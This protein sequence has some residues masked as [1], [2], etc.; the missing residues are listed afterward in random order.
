MF[1]LIK[2][3]SCS[4]SD[5]D[6]KINAVHLRPQERQVKFNSALQELYSVFS[7]W[8]A[9][10]LAKI[11][12]IFKQKAIAHMLWPELGLGLASRHRNIYLKHVYSICQPIWGK[13]LFLAITC[14]AFIG[15]F[16]QN[17]WC[18][19]LSYTIKKI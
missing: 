1:V 7:N 19:L 16:F 11:H 14:I 4:T 15:I 5:N 2:R 10:D 3:K 12:H 13:P 6:L 17:R 18:F 8:S 9:N